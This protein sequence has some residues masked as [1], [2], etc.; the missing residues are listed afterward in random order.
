MIFSAFRR[1]ATSSKDVELGAGVSFTVI[2]T[3]ILTAATL[4]LFRD[5][6][7]AVR[8]VWVATFAAITMLLS[9][10]LTHL[11][12]G[13][14]RHQ[15]SAALAYGYRVQAAI[16]LLL[17]IPVAFSG[18][19]ISIGWAAVALGLA[20]IG[21]K[22]DDKPARYAA[23]AAWTLAV[24]NCLFWQGRNETETAAHAVWLTLLGQPILAW[25]VIG[26]DAGARRPRNRPADRGARCQGA[27]ILSFVATGV[28]VLVTMAAL[29]P[30]GSTAVLLAY[31]WLLLGGDMVLPQLKLLPQSWIILGVAAAKWVVVDTIAAR[32]SPNWDAATYRPLFN[33]LMLTGVALAGSIVG[34]YR[35][36]R[37][38]IQRA[39]PPR[40]KVAAPSR[41]RS[42]S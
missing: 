23:V 33:P 27:P 40:A 41:R 34:I 28:F 24:I 8:G 17:A 29:P 5:A 31:A 10:G 35:L 30:I 25:S 22:L 15:S 18:A 20:A 2:V 42:S 9:V 12:R 14:R 7:P 6:T 3:A 19:S 13:R 11:L 26:V 4:W 1:R 32:M 38:A 39:S 37:D 16:L 21:A 36:R